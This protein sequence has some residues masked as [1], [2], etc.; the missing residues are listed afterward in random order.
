[1]ASDTVSKDFWEQ[2]WKD[3][4]TGW[5]LSQVSPPLKEYIDTIS[6]K[7]IAILIP[8]CGN[9]YEAEYLLNKGFKNVTLIDI[10]PTLIKK[11]QDK[12]AGK[13]IKVVHGDFFQHPGKYDLILEQTFFCAINPSLRKQYVDKCHSLLK[14]NGKIAGLL[15]NTVFEKEGPPF[16][17]TKEEYKALFNSKFKLLQFEVCKN[18]IEPRKGN[19]LFIEFEKK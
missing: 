5:D 8:G 4:Q 18:S 6:D 16:G 12:F 11:L 13:P 15:F 17:G 19:E 14:T 7:N 1:M 9:A 2:R 10:A 3:Q